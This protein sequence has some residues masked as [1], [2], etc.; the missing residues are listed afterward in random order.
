MLF[1]LKFCLIEYLSNVCKE[2][3]IQFLMLV[4][5]LLFDFTFAELES[6]G[7][8]AWTPPVMNS[9]WVTKELA[10]CLWCI[11][12]VAELKT[13]NQLNSSKQIFCHWVLLITTDRSCRAVHFFYLR[14]TLSK[15]ISSSEFTLLCLVPLGVI[16][17]YFTRKWLKSRT[18]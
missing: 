5:W 1:C 18:D 13:A 7:G 12:S 14:S 6:R 3:F 10:G 11:F 17:V 2:T 16:V 15:C 4:G 9:A 8:A